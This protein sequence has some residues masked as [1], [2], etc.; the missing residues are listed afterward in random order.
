MDKEQWKAELEKAELD[1]FLRG[2][3]FSVILIGLFHGFRFQ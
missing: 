3:V 2:I 1:W